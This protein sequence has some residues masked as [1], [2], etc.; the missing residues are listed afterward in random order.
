MKRSRLIALVS[1]LAFTILLY[2]PE[3]RS[4]GLVVD[5]GSG[6]TI[7]GALGSLKP[8]DTLT[9]RGTCNES[10]AIQAEVSRITLNGGGSATIQSPA[11]S[12]N[13]IAIQGR[14]ITVRG[15]TIS[16]GNNG[17]IVQRG[18]TAVIDGNTI[19]SNVRQGILLGPGSSASIINNT[20]ENNQ[21]G[22]TVDDNSSARIGWQVP[23]VL[24]LPNTIRNNTDSGIFV[25]HNSSARIIG[26]TISN[27]GGD[28]IQ[29][30]RAS[31]AD[32]TDNIINGNVRNGIAVSGSS[33]I[34]LDFGRSQAVI[35]LNRTDAGTSN[36][37]FGLAC[38]VGAYVSGSLGTLTGA[39]G[40]MQADSN[41]VDGLRP[42]VLSISFDP[43]TVSP[44]GTFTTAF[45]GA[46]LSAQTYFD[47]RFRTPG[48]NTDQ[49]AFNWQ[50]GTSATHTVPA[51][52]QAGTYV[53]ASVR[54]HRDIADHSGPYIAVSASLTVRP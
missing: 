6:G 22:I 50:Q 5:C 45:S 35:Q 24:G 4:Q 27:N 1:F 10:V 48:S 3:V 2:P 52:T 9:V 39:K 32:I 12:Q 17:I 36:G 54:A 13:A 8:G 28:G 44:G 47:I 46:G 31:Q 25:L 19:R 30:E 38:S 34:D 42:T 33:G 37:G 49:E 14:E 53:V 41:C 29:I 43:I 40:A 26:A 7:R 20:I 51:S 11:P 15:F 23:T 16:G 18:G 21:W